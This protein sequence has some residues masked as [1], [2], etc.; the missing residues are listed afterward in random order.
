MEDL[1]G[2]PM[3]RP[4]GIAPAGTGGRGPSEQ[5]T[6]PVSLGLPGILHAQGT[7]SAGPHFICGRLT[8][9]K[10]CQVGNLVKTQAH[11]F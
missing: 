2:G 8:L 9:F 5:G 10:N 4:P 3:F 6:P 1:A 11:T 7:T